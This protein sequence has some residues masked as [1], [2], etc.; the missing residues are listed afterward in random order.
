[1]VISYQTNQFD[2]TFR[3]EVPENFWI[4]IQVASRVGVLDG[5]LKGN[6]KNVV[7][8]YLHQGFVPT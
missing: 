1:M 6:I 4:S 5:Y 2:Y 3:Y 7:I 8:T